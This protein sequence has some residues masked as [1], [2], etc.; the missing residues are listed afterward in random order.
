MQVYSPAWSTVTFSTMS[1]FDSSREFQS[2]FFWGFP[3]VTEVWYEGDGAEYAIFV[4]K[5]FSHFVTE[6]LRGGQVRC[7]LWK[8]PTDQCLSRVRPV[9][10]DAHVELGVSLADQHQPLT[11][12]Q[13]ALREGQGDIIDLV[14]CGKGRADTGVRRRP[15]VLQRARALSVTLCLSQSHQQHSAFGH[16][17]SNIRTL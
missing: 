12:R 14:S 7:C 3:C 17:S 15:I 9:E 1:V 5:G 2:F 13:L 16:H 11:R 10:F 4:S 6:S 8:R